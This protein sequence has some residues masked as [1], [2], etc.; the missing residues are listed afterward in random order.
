MTAYDISPLLR[1]AIGFDR[2]A[3][4]ASMPELAATPSYPPYNIEMTGEDTYRLTLAVAGFGPDD[5]EIVAQDGKL[6]LTGK[7]AS[8]GDAGVRYLHRGIAGRSFERRF[9]LADH[10][11]VEGAG[12]EN[13]LLSI[14]LRRVVPEAMKPRRIQIAAKAAAVQPEPA[15]EAPEAAAAA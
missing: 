7:V 11:V 5:I 2:L 3:R 9:E 8:S 4:L 1:S 13:G 14:E 12:L 6:V 15:L 10:L